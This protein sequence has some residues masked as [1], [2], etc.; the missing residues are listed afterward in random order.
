[1]EELSNE[2]ITNNINTIEELEAFRKKITK[3]ERKKKITIILSLI[4][5]PIGF[6]LIYIL[7]Y[8]LFS[9]E[10]ADLIQ[11]FFPLIIVLFIILKVISASQKKDPSNCQKFKELYKKIVVLEILK[12][13]FSNINYEP[14]KE[15]NLEIIKNTDLV[16]TPDRYSS[17]DYISAT[18]NNIN[19]E[20]ADVLLE[21]AYEDKYGNYTIMFKGQWY[22]FDFK[23]KAFKSDIQIIE[24]NFYHTKRWLDNKYNKIELEDI[25]FNKQFSVFAKNDF[26]VFYILTPNIIEKIKI[27]NKKIPGQLIF[28]FKD[29]KLHI[30]VNNNK[31]SY[32]PDLH[33]H[34]SIEEAEKNIMNELNDI[35]TFINDLQLDKSLFK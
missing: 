15:L 12:K 35:I 3:K 30:G 20:T 24:N 21:S 7:V 10:E 9:K 5:I 25:S 31:N 14:N 32:E 28:C 11:A 17:N 16:I 13:V 29:N 6:L 8:K 27:L 19:F 26:D 1:M 18:Y 4:F 33:K 22:I 34:I 2:D 23:R